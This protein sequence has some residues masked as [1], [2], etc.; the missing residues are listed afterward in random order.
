MENYESAFNFEYSPAK[1]VMVTL[2][3]IRRSDV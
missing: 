1:T 3:A 2:A